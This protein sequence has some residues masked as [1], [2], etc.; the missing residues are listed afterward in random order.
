M[1][2]TG[3]W[4]YG[5]SCY[6]VSLRR[7]DMQWKVIIR[8]ARNVVHSST[9]CASEVQSNTQLIPCS[10]HFAPLLLWKQGLRSEIKISGYAN[11][12]KPS[13]L[14]YQFKK[15]AVL[16]NQAVSCTL[17]YIMPIE[18]EVC[19]ESHETYFL[20]YSSL[21]SF[22]EKEYPGEFFS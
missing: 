2:S 5:G 10:G 1:K 17:S 3:W 9:R 12:R 19:M 21:F 20:T 8:Q 22:Q 7:R 15:C 18:L 11:R 6:S 16:P 14:G 13:E 4:N